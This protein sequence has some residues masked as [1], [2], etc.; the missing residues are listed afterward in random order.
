MQ[1]FQFL[2]MPKENWALMP[3]FETI[4]DK[5]MR[6]KFGTGHASIQSSLPGPSKMKI[7][8]K[9]NLDSIRRLAKANIPLV[10]IDQIAGK[11]VTADEH[12]SIRWPL[13]GV[14][15]QWSLPDSCYTILETENGKASL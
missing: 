10:V 4:A 8:V 3:C 5:A 13:E 11:V 15:T 12:G 6:G 1:G 14:D 2:G 7:R 9:Q